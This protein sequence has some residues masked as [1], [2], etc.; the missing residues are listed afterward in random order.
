M[1]V[2]AW[3][4]DPEACRWF[5]GSDVAG[6]RPV[7][8]R[9]S[10]S[11]SSFVQ[12]NLASSL[13]LRPDTVTSSLSLLVKFATFPRLPRAS[14]ACAFLPTDIDPPLADVYVYASVSSFF[15]RAH[16]RGLQMAASLDRMQSLWRKGDISLDTLVWTEGMGSRARLRSVS[17]L[18]SR[19]E[20]SASS[21]LPSP[22]G[23]PAPAW[24]EAS[25]KLLRSGG[26]GG[27]GGDGDGNGLVE[28][29]GGGSGGD[30]VKR[31]GEAVKRRGDAV[32]RGGGGDGGG[33][34]LQDNSALATTDWRRDGAN[35]AIVPTTERPHYHPHHH[36]VAIEHPNRMDVNG[37]AGEAAGAEDLALRGSA[38]CWA[39]RGSR[40]RAAAADAAAG[41]SS[42]TMV[43]TLLKELQVTTNP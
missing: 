32:K 31:G 16:A 37:A 30:A 15:P 7:R 18:R 19:L 33:D 11:S 29:D 8:Q 22:V 5:Y 9:Q 35:G 42:P 17:A 6:T 38:S 12:P 10:K 24:A 28:R 27:G 1:G 41:K 34:G 26:G 43:L 2:E 23:K 4:G 40:Q 21:H 20:A 3:T 36:A 39:L 13:S 25:Q 14:H